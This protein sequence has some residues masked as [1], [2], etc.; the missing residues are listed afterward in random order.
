MDA[1]RRREKIT[2]RLTKKLDRSRLL[3]TAGSDPQIAD[4]TFAV[5][6]VEATGFSKE[7]QVIEIGL[8]RFTADGQAF[9]QWGTLINP[10]RDLEAYRVHRLS[11]FAYVRHAPSFE[12]IAGDLCQRLTGTVLVSH[13]LAYDQ[14]M[15]EQE[16]E[17]IGYELPAIPGLCTVRL[18]SALGVPHRRLEDCCLQ[19]GLH[20]PGAAHTAL[21]DAQAA[22]RLLAL[23]LLTFQS[24]GVRTLRELGC[25]T[26]IPSP[27]SWPEV[28]PSGLAYLREA[29]EGVSQLPRQVG[30]APPTERGHA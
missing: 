15:I 6:D 12:D 21:A 13:N 11:R 16:F 14:R 7:D 22:S 3:R 20:P 10:G 28:A 25:E 23:Y 8:V 4:C 18:G 27:D 24:N 19:F 17:R 2:K 5:L 26:E 9:D 30:W 29:H 1:G